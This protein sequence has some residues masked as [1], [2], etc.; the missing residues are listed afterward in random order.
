MNSTLSPRK[1]LPSSK[2]SRAPEPRG[3]AR[4]FAR[5][6]PGFSA[7]HPLLPA[8]I[9]ENV[10]REVMHVLGL[11]RFPC[12]SWIAYLEQRAETLYRLNRKFRRWMDG[13]DDV[14]YCHRC[15]R[16]WLYVGLHRTRYRYAR[17][18]PQEM[19]CGDSPLSYP[20]A[21]HRLYRLPPASRRRLAPH[22][23][24]SRPLR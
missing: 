13:P 4:W 23:Q 21:A 1:K 11:A 2:A 9:A 24:L 20:V 19:H 18:L 5:P 12:R 8:V 3:A 14:A 10:V 15:M 6:R 16:N 17:L 7:D 22:S